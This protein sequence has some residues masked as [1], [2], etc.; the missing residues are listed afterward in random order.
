MLYKTLSNIQKTGSEFLI[1]LNKV[2]SINSA[3]Y[4]QTLHLLSYINW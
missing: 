1:L 3:Q 4:K 2:Y